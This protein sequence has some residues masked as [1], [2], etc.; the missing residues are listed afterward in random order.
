[1]TLIRTTPSAAS[2]EDFELFSYTPLSS[3][4]SSPSKPIQPSTLSELFHKCIMFLMQLP[5]LM[6]T[7]IVINLL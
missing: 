2:V 3:S 6:T 7:T 5:F 1:M 4:P